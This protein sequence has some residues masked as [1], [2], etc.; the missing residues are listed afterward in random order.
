MKEVVGG[1]IT[2]YGHNLLHVNLWMKNNK[3]MQVDLKIGTLDIILLWR[4]LR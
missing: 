1:D 4:R 2:Y 3:F